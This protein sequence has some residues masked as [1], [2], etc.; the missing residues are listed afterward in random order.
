MRTR[1]RAGLGERGAAAV[2]MAL[3]LPVLLLILG[4]VIDFGRMY[5]GEV[6]VTNAARDGARMAATKAYSSADVDL[7]AR[8]ATGG[9]TPFVAPGVTVTTWPGNGA[10][11]TTVCQVDTSPGSSSAPVAKVTVTATNF[12]WLMLNVVPRLVGGNI[13]PPTITATASMQCS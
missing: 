11:G 2:E 12:R 10:T 4:G 6:I 13:A 7:Q 5:L 8:K 1:L 9:L 3:V